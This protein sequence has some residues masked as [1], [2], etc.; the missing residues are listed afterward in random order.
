MAHTIIIPYFNPRDKKR[1]GLASNFCS[2]GFISYTFH[3]KLYGRTIYLRCLIGILT[4]SFYYLNHQGYIIKISRWK[5]V[6][7]E[8]SSG[9]SSEFK[10]FSLSPPCPC[11][12]AA[13]HF[14]LTPRAQTVLCTDNLS[15]RS[16]AAQFNEQVGCGTLCLH[17]VSSS[18]QV[19]LL[20]GVS[21]LTTCL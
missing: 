18:L 21:Y 11:S 13:L 12:F 14:C 4:Y 16:E 7:L 19:L 2:E 1:A 8:R 5:N 17:G 10:S 9:F 3:L 15:M 20:R 6:H